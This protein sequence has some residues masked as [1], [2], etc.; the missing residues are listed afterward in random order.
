[1]SLPAR[2]PPERPLVI[3]HRGASAA[4]AEHTIAA[5]ALAIEAGADGLECDVRLTSDGHL[6][7][8]H[9]RRINRTSNGSGAVSS[10]DLAHLRSLDFAVAHD[11]D[12]HDVLTLEELLELVRD[13]GRPVR[14]LIDAKHPNRHGARLEHELVRLLARFGWTGA[15]DDD[16]VTVMSFA[17]IAIRRV[18]QLAPNLPTAVLMHAVPGVRRTGLLPTGVGI[19][20][21]SLF[22]LRHDPSFVE[23]A[24]ALG[25]LVY[26]WTVDDP[27]DIRRMV[28]LGVDAVITNRPAEA[29]ATLE[30]RS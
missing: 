13:A 12:V 21:P 26:V 27:A 29:I 7:C 1:V 24:H 10:R 16:T 25:N 18:R 5:Y 22:L 23:R 14:L 30:P 3:A 15:G 9:D 11:P 20:G 2:T 19:A 8:I 4:R 6:V 28:H 17:R